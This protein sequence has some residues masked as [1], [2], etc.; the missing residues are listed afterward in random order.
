MRKPELRYW[1]LWLFLLGVLVIVF[2]QVISGYNINRL[3]QGN[4]RLL[5]EL[6]VQ[7]DLRKLESNVLAIESDIRGAV[8]NS[9]QEVLE[10]IGNEFKV[11]ES[12]LHIIQD[13]FRGQVPAENV[14]EL[15][16]LVN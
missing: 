16:Q 7:N 4:K 6:K 12:E 3:I 2:L 13:I 5:N 10:N 8:I 1:V 14:K 11:I 9:D 15:N